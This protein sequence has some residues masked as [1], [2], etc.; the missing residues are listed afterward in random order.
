MKNS[1]S[2]F[3]TALLIVFFAGCSSDDSDD[4]GSGGV[5]SKKV[6]VSIVSEDS[7]TTI[8]YD[9]QLRIT[10]MT[11]KGI[12]LDLVSQE[13]YEYWSRHIITYNSINEVA[14]ITWETSFGNI[15]Y[16]TNYDNNSNKMLLTQHKLDN[17]SLAI[18]GPITYTFDSNNRLSR[19]ENSPFEYD[20]AGHL[21]KTLNSSYK[22][23]N[24]P[25]ISRNINSPFWLLELIS[26]ILSNSVI[27]NAIQINY[28][29]TY[30]KYKTDI[31]YSYDKDGFPKTF[32]YVGGYNNNNNSTYTI[33]YK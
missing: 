19:I 27:N 15:M 24:N 22:Y 31:T 10:K 21:I 29:N 23:D 28:D 3:L 12:S 7:E 33:K 16:T 18:Y 2:L 6:P 17:S 1:I 20:E 30:E 13:K 4:S 26:D 32:R 11:S 9:D 25:G 14:Y 8:E 5:N